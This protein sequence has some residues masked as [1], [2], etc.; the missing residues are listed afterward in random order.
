MLLQNHIYK[1]KSELTA[2]S[3][4]TRDYTHHVSL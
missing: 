3:D 1:G 2:L 4:G